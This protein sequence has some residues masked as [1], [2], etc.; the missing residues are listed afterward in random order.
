MD[1][2]K[3]NP[4]KLIFKYSVPAIIGM[5][6]NALYNLVDRIFIAYSVGPQ[7]FSSM[8]VTGAVFMILQSFGMMIGIGAATCISIKLGEGDYNNAEKIL[9]NA[10]I[11][12]GAT[13]LFIMGF[14]L[15]FMRDVLFFFGASS[16][17]MPYAI[18]YLKV[19]ILG[20]PFMTLG[21]GL[22]H[23]I[24]AIGTPTKAML[25]MVISSLSNIILDAIFIF[26]LGWGVTGAAIATVIAQICSMIYILHIVRLKTNAIQLRASNFTPSPALI[27][28]IYF[29]GLSVFFT[30][31]ASSM[32]AAVANIQLLH[33]ANYYA[34][35]AYGAINMTYTI[36]LMPVSGIGQGCQPVIGYN[37]G[38]GLYKRSRKILYYSLF[39]AFIV[40]IVGWLFFHLKS[41]L[42][43]R[44]FTNESTEIMRY[45]VPGLEKLTL[46]F[47]LATVQAVGQVYFQSIGSPKIT[48]FLSALRQLVF[49]IPSLYILPIFF[50]INGVW[51]TIPVAE[52]LALLCT[53]TTLFF[54]ITKNKKKEQ[55]MTN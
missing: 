42:L 4:V 30:Q 40:G 35:G 24:R 41:E 31:A 45:A 52:L 17:T 39:M 26:I 2:G 5:L 28:R 55:V 12:L 1:L 29:T 8:T 34:V 21:N 14:V 46:L 20:F 3:D 33:Y 6:I 11:S 18:E 47:P 7:A 50:G 19:I 25:S 37:H 51:Y 13:A 49:I 15:I 48:L 16:D 36:F 10:V 43:M 54:V 38:A 9:G 23:I 53:S 32:I 44:Y 22:Y 27:K